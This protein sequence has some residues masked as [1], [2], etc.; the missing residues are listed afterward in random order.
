M[1]EKM[2]KSVSI[3]IDADKMAAEGNAGFLQG[4]IE[5]ISTYFGPTKS[6]PEKKDPL[7]AYEGYYSEFMKSVDQE[8]RRAMFVV[9]EP[10]VVDLHGDTYSATEIEKACTNFNLHCMKAN[11]FHRVQTEDAIIEQSFI[12]PSSFALEDGREIKKG[13]W[14][15]WYHFPKDNE[16]SEA[17]WKMVKDGEIT[18]VSI[19]CTALVETLNDD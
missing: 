17:I 14:L 19:G 5:L 18:G 9:L 11:L 6:E 1:T 8:Q 13:T 12:A 7:A 15:M 10:D 2:N 3:E 16:N 4:F